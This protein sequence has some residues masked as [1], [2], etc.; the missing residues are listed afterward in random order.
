MKYS[1]TSCVSLPPPF[2]K[3]TFY[4]DQYGAVLL[5]DIIDANVAAHVVRQRR[6]H[7][8]ESNAIL[9][10]VSFQS[11]SL[12]PQPPQPGRWSGH[13]AVV[14]AAQLQLPPLGHDNMRPARADDWLT[15]CWNRRQAVHKS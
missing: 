13:G 1:K 15:P 6:R 9:L 12:L 14:V 3:P 5:G 7:P 4:V 8:D 11:A 2:Q 10:Y